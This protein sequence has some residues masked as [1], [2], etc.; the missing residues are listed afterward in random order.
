[1]AE[2]KKKTQKK[3]TKSTK[4]SKIKLTFS[5]VASGAKE[6]NVLL[7][8]RENEERDGRNVIVSAPLIKG[9]PEILTVHRDEVIEVTKTQCDELEKLGLVETEEEYKQ[10]KAF[11]DNLKEQHP[12]KLSYAQ[13]DGA[14]GDL[15]TARD[16]Q[17]KVY[18]DKL[19][20]L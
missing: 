14:N 3:S 16:S 4:S 20:R 10:R 9:L 8:T 15:L 17:H 19:I 18:M 13:M 1:M 7:R 5:P 11:V 6:M 12:D 2:K